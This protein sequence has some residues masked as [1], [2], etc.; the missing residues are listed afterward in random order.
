MK[1]F[2]LLLALQLKNMYAGLFKKKNRKKALPLGM[3]AFIALACVSLYE[4]SLIGLLP[5]EA[6]F[7]GAQM[8]VGIAGMLCFISALTTSHLTL[9]SGKDYERLSHLPV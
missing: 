7:V 5:V 6:T 3:I 4:Y 2:R 8:F 9:L 1:K